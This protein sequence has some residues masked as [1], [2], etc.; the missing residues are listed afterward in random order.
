[1]ASD[2][3]ASVVL[4]TS[5]DTDNHRFGTGFVIA[6]DEH[7]TYL[8]S[9]AHVVR[10]IGG[11]DKVIIGEQ[12]ANVIACGSE[13]GPDDL[14]VLQVEVPLN[15]P[16]PLK[17]DSS[18]RT[19]LPFIATGFQLFGKNFLIRSIQGTLGNQVGLAGRGLTQRITAWDL[20]ITDDYQLQPGYS[21]SPVV[22]EITGNVFAVVSHRQGKGEKGLAIS[23]ETLSKIWSDMPCNLLQLPIVDTGKNDATSARLSLET[24]VFISYAR[25]DQEIA[26]K[27]Y[28]DL[29]SAGVNPWLDVEDILPGQNWKVVTKRALKES[30]Y[31]LVLL[32][33]NSISKRGFI[34]KELKMAL[35]LLDEFPLDDIF[36]IPI[37]LDSCKPLDE[38]LQDIQ[39]VELSPYETGF[40]QILRAMQLAEGHQKSD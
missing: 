10:D 3:Q 31:V 20:K 4:V 1:M 12:Q 21:G 17:L 39:W 6:N 5:S 19:G 18:G 16:P 7:N 36:I 37:R 11:V 22:N 24:K 28:N 32:S 23:I 29:K 38:R 15:T 35:D 34:Q 13:D 8:L 40:N 33:S 14:A 26:R 25:E 27:L 9:C 2:I 30:T